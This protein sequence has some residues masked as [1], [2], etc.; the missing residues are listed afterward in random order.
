MF[1]KAERRLT[2]GQTKVLNKTKFIVF[3]V[4]G[5]MNVKA[6]GIVTDCKIQ[7]W[8]IEKGF[9][10]STPIGDNCR[11]DFIADLGKGNLLRI[12][13]KTGNK[14][15]NKGCL[16]F[17]T[18]SNRSN[19]NKIERKNYNEDDIDYFATIDND[20]GQIYM[21]SIK[22]TN[23]TQFS[24]RLTEPENP[25]KTIHMAN[26]YQIEKVIKAICSDSSAVRTG[27]L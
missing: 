18:C 5:W 15:R 6:K 27:G 19:C 10:V 12:Q 14:N 17:N 26:D 4:G 2:F 23:G 3:N 21:V 8:F 16:T 1:G 9:N 20:T 22:E 13:S 24:L 11:Y 25:V 7:L